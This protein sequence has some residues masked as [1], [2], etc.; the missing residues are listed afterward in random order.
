MSTIKWV[1]EMRNKINADRDLENFKPKQGSGMRFSSNQKGFT[2]VEMLTTIGI[3]GIL[4]S[5]AI[6]SFHVWLHK[7]R[8]DSEVSRLYFNLMAA[9]QRAI[10]NNSTII[11]TFSPGTSSY[12]IHDDVNENGA[13]DAGEPVS[14]VD[15]DP[16]NNMIFGYVPGLLGVWGEPI[17]NTISLTSGTS[18]S[19]FSTGRADR[20][21]AIYMIPSGDLPASIME[22]QRAVKIIQATGNL[23]I[24]KY[25]ANGTPGPWS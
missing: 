18:L 11:V 14:Q 21:G 23:E 10:R 20:S 6:P 4:S 3:I 17:N 12:S 5:V 25:K 8:A 15:L 2:L 13:A 22:N 7:Y 16:D 1:R 9:K 19:F 24:M